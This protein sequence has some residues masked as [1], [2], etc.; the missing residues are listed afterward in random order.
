MCS[1]KVSERRT[2]LDEVDAGRVG[3]AGRAQVQRGVCEP[4]DVTV[5]E[6]GVQ[7]S[8]DSRTARDDCL[9]TRAASLELPTKKVDGGRR[10]L[11]LSAVRHL[12]G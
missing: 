8:Q 11:I 6:R 2:P 7:F 4:A 3:V 9:E 12:V 10:P 5:E 1:Q